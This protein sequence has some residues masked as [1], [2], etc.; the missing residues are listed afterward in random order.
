MNPSH[1]DS[2]GGSAAPRRFEVLLFSLLRE[3]VGADRVAVL[4]SPP[5]TGERLLDRLTAERPE[6]APFR[7]VIRLAVDQTY[8]PASAPI[9][10]GAEI[11]LITPVSGG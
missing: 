11:A 3:R 5:W 9:P 8:Q 4:V 7:A 10:P 6:L 2:A 1:V